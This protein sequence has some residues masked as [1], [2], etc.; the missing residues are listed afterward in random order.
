[1]EILHRFKADHINKK[2]GQTL[3]V[4]GEKTNITG[5]AECY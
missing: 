4:I 3:K 2:S 5:C 1:M